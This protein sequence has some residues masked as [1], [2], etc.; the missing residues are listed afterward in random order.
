VKGTIA[1]ARE[2]DVTA[3]FILR[4]RTKQPFYTTFYD[5]STPDHQSVS[6]ADLNRGTH[7]PSQTTSPPRVYDVH[8]FAH[9]YGGICIGTRCAL[10]HTGK[11]RSER[12]VRFP[13]PAYVFCIAGHRFKRH[14][15]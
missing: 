6:L 10:T 3:R 8:L 7:V 13:C 4:A 1:Y 15:R 14:H 11:S 12:G 5:N 9:H 2:L